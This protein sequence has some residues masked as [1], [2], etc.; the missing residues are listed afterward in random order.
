[1]KAKHQPLWL[2]LREREPTLAAFALVMLLLAVPT[3][4]ALM[5]DTRLVHGVNVWVKPLKFMLSLALFAATTA[6][7]FDLLP[8]SQR[9]KRPARVVVWTIVVAGLGEVAYISLQAWLGQPSHYNLADR[10]HALMY[11]LMG[12]GALSLMLTQLVLAHQI[13]RHA[14]P[15]VP[16]LWRQAVLLALCMSFGLG[17]G[18]A[19]L[20]ANAQPPAAA[21]VPFLGWHVGGG[22]LRP[23]HF[24]GSHAV[25]AV[26]LV[27]W[28]L[29]QRP[30]RPSSPSSPSSPSLRAHDESRRPQ[31]WLLIFALAYAALW[32]G[33]LL[34]GLQGAVWL[35][36]P[37]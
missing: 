22:D 36:P 34:R 7:F 35:R 25:Q 11:Q 13:A 1:L 18:A 17:V 15:D 33:A 12:L 31:A 23:A 19:A 16:P 10:T 32:L 2:V 9:A 24:I 3:L 5:V 21:G 29:L 30:S 6:W 8:P 26:A 28:W 14:R 20:L 4:L 27:G 37:V